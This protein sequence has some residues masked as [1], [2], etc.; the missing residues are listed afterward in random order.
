MYKLYGYSV[1]TANKLHAIYIYIYTNLCIYIYVHTYIYIYSVAN[2]CG[3]RIKGT[4]Q[5]LQERSEVPLASF[6]VEG[7]EEAAWEQHGSVKIGVPQKR[8]FP[9]LASPSTRST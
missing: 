3:A 2:A 8:W 6:C 5:V 9:F 4:P 7:A 1:Y